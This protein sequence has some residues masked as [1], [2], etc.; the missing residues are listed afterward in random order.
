MNILFNIIIITFTLVNIFQEV[1]ALMVSE[2]LTLI[3]FYAIGLT[4]KYSFFPKAFKFPLN[5]VDD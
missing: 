4:S 5:K 3:Q 2:D 1:H